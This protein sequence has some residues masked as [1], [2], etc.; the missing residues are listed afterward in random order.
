MAKL[1]DEVLINVNGG[2]ITYGGN[3]IDM[4]LTVEQLSASYPVILIYKSVLVQNGMWTQTLNA[5]CAQ[6]GEETVQGIIN[7]LS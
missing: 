2:V 4:S 3:E 5:I 6:Y 1:N 7:M